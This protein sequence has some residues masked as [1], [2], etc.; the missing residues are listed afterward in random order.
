M[1]KI[2]IQYGKHEQQ[3]IVR[4][5]LRKSGGRV[6]KH[7]LWCFASRVL[8]AIASTFLTY[9]CLFLITAE[10]LVLKSDMHISLAHFRTP[11]MSGLPEKY[12]ERKAFTPTRKIDGASLPPPNIPVEP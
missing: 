10:K 4:G 6:L 8:K 5:I 7:F 9:S 1:V 12:L 3:G 2:P 11:F